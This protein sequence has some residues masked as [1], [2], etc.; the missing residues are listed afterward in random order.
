MRKADYFPPSVTTNVSGCV[1]FRGEDH[2]EEDRKRQQ[3][4]EQ[5]AYLLQQM[6]EN[7]A[8]KELEKKQNLM[9]DKQRVAINEQVNRNQH[10]FVKENYEMSRRMLEEN[11]ERDQMRKTT[12]YNQKMSE[13]QRDIDD[14]AM[15]NATRLD[16]SESKSY[17]D[18]FLK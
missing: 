11:L 17:A 4:A 15:T 10:T 6:E 14:L 13:R 1:G 2:E 7:K 8:K 3:A 5:R 9:Y 12:E 18:K 16:F